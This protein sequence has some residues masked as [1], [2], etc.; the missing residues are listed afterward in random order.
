LEK[1]TFV[2]NRS[3][4][5]GAVF[6]EPGAQVLIKTSVLQANAVAEVALSSNAAGGQALFGP[7]QAQLCTLVDHESGALPMSIVSTDTTIDSSILWNNGPAPL[8]SGVAVT[9]STVEGGFPGV[10]NNSADPRFWGMD[11]FHL[12]P[13]SPARRGANPALG[14]PV[15][16]QGALRF[17]F[18]Y[19]S[20]VC[21][22]PITSFGSC[23]SN[24]NSTGAVAT[25]AMY[26]SRNY[27]ENKIKLQVNALPS[28]SIGYFLASQTPDNVPMFGNSSGVLCL[29]GQ[30]HRKHD[31]LSIAGPNQSIGRSV[32]L[33]ALAYDQVVQP[34]STWYFQFWY[35]DAGAPQGTNNTSRNLVVIFQ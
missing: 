18:G 6:A 26:R 4:Q 15:L 28:G 33:T 30:I 25:P 5:G 11:D 13:H 31:E 14:S 1:N 17:N 32:D 16:D 24:P 27:P 2:A 19:C 10:G 29:G 7:I 3:E 8:D 22:P 23:N 9:Y 21:Y 34:G 12:L 20:D 35:R